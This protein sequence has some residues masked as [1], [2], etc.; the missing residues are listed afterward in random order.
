MGFSEIV[1]INDQIIEYIIETYTL[2][3]GVRKLK[4]ILFDLYGEI[5][6]ELL[7]YKNSHILELPIIL[8]RE[9]IDT[10]YLKKYNKIHEKKINNKNKIGTING[11]WA[12]SLGKGGIIPIETMFY[13]TSTFLDLKLTGLQGDVMKESMNVAK[14]LAWC[15]TGDNIKDKLLLNFDKTKCQG[16]HIH[17]PDGSIS[18][19]GPSAGTAITVAIY[20]LL[21]DKY[22]KNNVALTG[23]IDLQGNIHAIGGLEIKILGGLRAGVTT[24]IYPSETKSDY[25][26]FLEKYKNKMSLD[27]IIF[28]E[29]SHILD[30]FQYVFE[31]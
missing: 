26:N 24:F 31:D 4:E 18:K 12:N 22:I 10:H 7:D 9:L 14:S 6:I 30:V 3:S 23:E 25:E 21:N 28:Y 11:L 29:V 19:D 16:L 17:C 1:E 8:T 27:N 15:L 20:S 5:N 2:E 13:P